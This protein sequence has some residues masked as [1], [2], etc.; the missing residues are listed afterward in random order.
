MLMVP[1]DSRCVASPTGTQDY[2]FYSMG[3]WSWSIPYISGLYALA[4]QIKPD[5]TPEAF[6]TEAMKSGNSVDIQKDGKNYK[7][8]KIVDPVKLMQSLK[9]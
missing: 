7:V 4:C 9:K 6:W 8:E 3:G 5:I 2:V 1:M